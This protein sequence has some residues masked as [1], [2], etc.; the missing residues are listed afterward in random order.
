VWEAGT[1]KWGD[2]VRVLAA[3]EASAREPRKL[4]AALEQ[5]LSGPEFAGVPI[6]IAGG[7]DSMSHLDYSEIA[8][9][10]HG[11]VVDFPTSRELSDAGFR[12]AYR[13][14]DPHID[15]R[16]DRTWTPRFPEQSQDRIDHVYYR[17]A[18]L[19]A[20]RSWTIET[21]VERFPSDHTALAVDFRLDTGAAPPDRWSVSSCAVVDQRLASDHRPVLAEFVLGAHR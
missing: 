19:R 9:A 5:R 18:P 10:Q 6:V 21:N 4:H 15:R 16:A 7:F 11:C 12:D 14:L 1:R 17:G 2:A 8:L 20:Q 3:C 13:E